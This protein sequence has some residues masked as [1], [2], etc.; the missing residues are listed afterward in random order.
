MGLF[1]QFTWRIPS[2]KYKQVMKTNTDNQHQFETI[3]KELRENHPSTKEIIDKII[4]EHEGG[5]VGRLD[6]LYHIAE[7]RGLICIESFK[8]KQFLSQPGTIYISVGS[9]HGN[10]RITQA[11]A[12]ALNGIPTDRESFKSMLAYFSCHPSHRITMQEIEEFDQ[13]LHAINSHIELYAWGVE[14]DKSL[15]E[16]AVEATLIVLI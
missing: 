16:D 14:E 5:V 7:C 1:P 11:I 4:A 8:I 10:H 6:K 3:L 15:P 2:F 13:G 12:S 9:S